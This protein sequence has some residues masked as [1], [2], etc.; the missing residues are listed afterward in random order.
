MK[1]RISFILFFL[2][3]AGYMIFFPHQLKKEM[4]LMPSWASD[5]ESGESIYSEDAV[6]FRLGATLGYF[7]AS[8]KVLFSGDINHNAAVGDVFINYSSISDRLVIQD[9][10]GGIIGDIENAGLPFFI[11][12]RL[13]VI[14]PDRLTIEEYDYEGRLLLSIS[15]GSLITS[16]DAGEDII[17]LGMLNGEV[18]L[19]ENSSEPIFTYYSTDS[20]Y[21]ISYS[22]AVTDDGSRF[23]VVT[24]LYPQQ[25]VCFELRNDSYIP[26]FRK[27]VTDVYRRSIL[28]DYSDDG[29]LLYLENY[30]GIEIYRTATFLREEIE[31]AGS[32]RQAVIPGLREISYI[33]SGDSSK[34]MLRLYRSDLGC[35]ADLKIPAGDIYFYPDENC[36]YIGAEGR[37][38]RYDLIEG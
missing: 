4:I 16:I 26:V 5:I 11:G 21:S 25:L 33:V 36:I 10:S 20:R 28:M 13:F 38:V 8:G 14:S 32:L 6:P 7:S 22:C 15:P 27:D 18:A 9:C 37:I 35:I 31:T 12:S 3:F 1:K 17:I 24:G 29:K 30:Q 23:A 2:I 19:Y 34:S